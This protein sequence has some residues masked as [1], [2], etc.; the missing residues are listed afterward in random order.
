MGFGGYL[1]KLIFYEKFVICFVNCSEIILKDLLNMRNSRSS[2][3]FYI[4]CMVNYSE[5]VVNRIDK[6]MRWLRIDLLF[7]LVFLYL[8]DLD[9]IGYGFSIE[10]D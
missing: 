1:E 4:Y 6:I 10:S 7:R 5:F 9:S 8:E 3:L 2:W